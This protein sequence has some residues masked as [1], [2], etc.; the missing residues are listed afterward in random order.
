MQS[1]LSLVIENI[2]D[3]EEIIY[4]IESLEKTIRIILFEIRG[5]QAQL[6]KRFLEDM[7]RR[8]GKRKLFQ[9]GMDKQFVDFI[10]YKGNTRFENEKISPVGVFRVVRENKYSVID[11]VELLFQLLLEDMKQEKLS[12]SSSQE[13]FFKKDYSILRNFSKGQVIGSDN[14]IRTSRKR[15]YDLG[16]YIC[17]KMRFGIGIIE[18]YMQ[19]WIGFKSKDNLICFQ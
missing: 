4:S 19:N 12:R 17:Q 8:Y 3:T 5:R 2:K 16:N 13:R 9:F 6:E 7:Q 15:K 11:Q 1:Y 10:T 18:R 14:K